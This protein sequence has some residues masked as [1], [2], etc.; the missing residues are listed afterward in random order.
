MV[1][2]SNVPQIGQPRLI[3][4]L[5]SVINT[6]RVYMDPVLPS[7]IVTKNYP[8]SKLALAVNEL[9]KKTWLNT[10]CLSNLQTGM[11]SRTETV[12]SSAA[13][14]VNSIPTNDRIPRKC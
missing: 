14:T 7:G 5:N 8:D 3:T 1:L 13:A 6:S 10:A 4:I 11:I 12:D 2:R 9:D